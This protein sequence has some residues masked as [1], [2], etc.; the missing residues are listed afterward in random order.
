MISPA[1]PRSARSWWAP[2]RWNSVPSIVS[3]TPGWPSAARILRTTLSV[4]SECQS[5]ARTS[6][7]HQRASAAGRRGV[8]EDPAARRRRPTILPIAS[9][10]ASIAARR[11]SWRYRLLLPT[12]RAREGAR[13]PDIAGVDVA[14]GLE[15]RHAPLA[16][17]ELDRPVQ[18]R[19]SAVAPRAGVHDQAAMLRPDRLRDHLLE[20]RAHDQL[21][22]VL[23]DRRLHR[24]GRV[25]HR[26]RHLVAELGQRD[27]GALAEAV[28][29]RHQE[30]DPQRSRTHVDTRPSCSSITSRSNVKSSETCLPSRTSTTRT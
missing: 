16:H 13:G 11:T 20:H 2:K 8:V 29:R 10:S 14:V 24:G 3:S 5:I 25:D 21:R 17:A 1:R 6:W 12:S 23:A 15:H 22:P 4:P 26:D 30:Q 9:T 27:P 28:V 18:R 19:R 7:R